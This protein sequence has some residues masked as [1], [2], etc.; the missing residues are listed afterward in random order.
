MVSKNR[1]GR[2]NRLRG[3]VAVFA[4]VVAAFAVVPLAATAGIY[5]VSGSQVPVT[6]TLATMT[7]GLN[8][9]WTTL[10][11][12][13]RYDEQTGRLTA[14]GT[15][16]FQGC[17]DR[18]HDGCD[19]SDL[20]GAMFFKFAAWQQYDPQTFAF[21][22]GGCIHPVT[23][24]TGDFQGARGVIVMKD[25]PQPDGSISTS[26]WGVLTIPSGMATKSTGGQS[27]SIASAGLRTTCG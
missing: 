13:Y 25:T 1:S 6:D 15:E 5:A 8:G 26:Y 17:V 10:S 7:G 21:K 11:L 24:A 4:A 18:G 27:R 14:W 12:D 23:G 22:S 2:V 3:R 19:S 16:S 20:Q 9:D